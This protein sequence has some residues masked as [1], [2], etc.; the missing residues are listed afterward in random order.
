MNYH[1]LKI[2]GAFCPTCSRRVELLIPEDMDSSNAHF[3]ICFKCRKVS[4]FSHGDLVRHQNAAFLKNIEKQAKVSELVAEIPV[5]KGYALTGSQLRISDHQQTSQRNWLSLAA[6]EQIF[7]E[8]PPSANCDFRH[9][10]KTCKWCGCELPKGR[11]SFCKNACSR[12]YSQ[13]TFQQRTTASLPYRIACRD[14]FFCQITKRDLALTNQHGLRI[15]TPG[16]AMAIHHLVQVSE[17]GSDHAQNLVT[18]DAE[19]HRQYHQGQHEIVTQ[20]EHLKATRLTTA[21]AL[22]YA[23]KT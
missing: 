7:K 13:A 22:M 4:Q 6:Y 8:A 2:P 15:P 14:Q 3:Y 10:P 12:Q 23:K 16:T 18:L 5:K 21:N 20:I 17:G 11:R 9:S 19:I 1:H